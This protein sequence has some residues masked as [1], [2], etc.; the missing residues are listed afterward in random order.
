MWE[1]KLWRSWEHSSKFLL[2]TK[3]EELLENVGGLR[4][5]GILEEMREEGFSSDKGEDILFLFFPLISLYLNISFQM[6]SH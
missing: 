6:I 5:A 4:T 2:D 1:K 3:T